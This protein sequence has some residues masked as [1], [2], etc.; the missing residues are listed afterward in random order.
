MTK[1]ML[2]WWFGLCL[3][4]LAAVVAYQYGVYSMLMTADPTYISVSILALHVFTVF[5]I[6]YKTFRN[7][8]DTYLLWF[9]AEAQMGLGMM[10]TLV[11]FVIMFAGAFALG[12]NVENIKGI[13][14]AIALGTGTAVWTT[15]VGLGSSLILKTLTVNLERQGYGS[16]I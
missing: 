14:T 7:N 16:K 6:G 15:L 5:W 4:I 9:I 12:F 2:V 8:K 3:Q 13:I 11:G 1:N 10:G